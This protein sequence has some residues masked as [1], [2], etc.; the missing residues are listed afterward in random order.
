MRARCCAPLLLFCPII[1]RATL[2]QQR[3]YTAVTPLK[4]AIENEHA[5]VEQY[6][7]SVGGQEQTIHRAAF[8]GDVAFIQHQL[9]NRRGR[10]ACVNLTT[11]CVS[12]MHFLRFA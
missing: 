7:R 11:R 2:K 5:S 10:R 8:D 4:M 9:R 12:L 6:L 1:A 3:R